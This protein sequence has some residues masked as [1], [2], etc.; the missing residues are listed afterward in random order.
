MSNERDWPFEKIPDKGLRPWFLSA[1]GYLFALFTEVDE[2]RRAKQ[3]LLEQGVP[4]EDAR[5]YASAEILGIESHRTEEGSNL[6]RAVAAFTADDAV[7][8]LY[9]DTARA[10]GAALWLFSP[11]EEAANRL[12]RLLADFDYILLRYYSPEGVVTIH[13]DVD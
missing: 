11:T 4:D 6:A 13:G 2:A 9:L 7:K 12:V 5:L 3:S 1:D 10:G 8:R